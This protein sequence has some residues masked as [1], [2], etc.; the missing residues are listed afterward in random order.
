MGNGRGAS[1]RARAGLLAAIVVPLVLLASVPATAW[2][3][4]HPDERECAVCHSGHQ[5]ADV[6]SPVELVASRGGGPAEPEDEVPKV[7]SRRSLRRPA[8]APPA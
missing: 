5:S 4:E 1:L 3:E 7:P 8:R 6:S 2:H